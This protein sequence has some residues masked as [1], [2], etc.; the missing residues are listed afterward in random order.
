M[1]VR[2]NRLV[3]EQT[4]CLIWL[5][6]CVSTADGRCTE[7]RMGCRRSVSETQIELRSIELEHDFLTI[8]DAVGH[9]HFMIDT[10]IGFADN[11]DR[12]NNL[13]CMVNELL[14]NDVPNAG[15]AV[16]KY[17]PEIM[18]TD[19]E[20]VFDESGEFKG[21]LIKDFDDVNDIIK[22]EI[23]AESIEDSE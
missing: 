12:K 4:S 6:I 9:L 8:G 20:A 3:V 2:S 21:L 5:A 7:A 22:D 10:M 23:L 13:R 11:E 1:G 18:L 14:T 15:R 19:V 17:W 16:L